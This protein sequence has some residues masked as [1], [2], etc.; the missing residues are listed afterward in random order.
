M[1]QNNQ[2]Y[3]QTPIGLIPT[4]WE[5]KKLGEVARFINGK[6]YK[7]E[8]LLNEGKYKVLRVGNLNTSTEWYWSNLELGEDKYVNKGDLM[9][10]WSASF[11][12]SFWNGIKT[13][14]HYH[15]WKVMPTIADKRYL[16][17]YLLFDTD[18][19]LSLKQGGTMFHITKSFIEDRNFFLP[20]L[21]EQQKIAEILSTWDKAINNLQLIIKKIELRNK[22]LAF[23][24]LTGKK[25]VKGFEGKEFKKSF[26]NQVFKSVSVKNNTENVE[27]LSATQENGIIPRSLLE[28]R[29]T[30]PSGSL[31]TY[32]LVQKGDFVISLRS[33]QG[34]IEY[35]EYTGV[36]SPAY[37]V[38]KP[39][40]P[41][42]DNFYKY[43][44]KS[45]DLIGR[46]S[47]AVIG[48]RDGKN[49]SYDDFSTIILP[50]PSLEE[51][52]AIAEIL[53][54]AQQELKQYQEKLKALQQQKKGLMQQL[55]TG[56]I[57]TV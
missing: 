8:E 18:K 47:V 5:V 14:Y 45:R 46:L 42:N 10:A 49:I 12:P 23:S 38:L 16:Y 44:F 28:T 25:R 15:I 41:I 51:Q 36:V 35:S 22:A 40:N 31:N 26:A 24:L 17:Q 4:D 6:A 1:Q 21:P 19:M 11:G 27:L 29:V 33:F 39:I 30:M 34:G 3:K 43:Y 56:K 7:Q 48:I 57:R 32:K 9:Y 54:T 53:N 52:T 55:L 50:N 20:P 37:T 13:I 2:K